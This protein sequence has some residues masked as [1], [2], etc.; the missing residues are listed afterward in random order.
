MEEKL[1][2]KFCG[3]TDLRKVG[4]YLSPN[5]VR[6]KIQCKSCYRIFNAGLIEEQE[7]D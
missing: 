5:G 6:Q 3:S 2:C 4:K 7:E 1:V